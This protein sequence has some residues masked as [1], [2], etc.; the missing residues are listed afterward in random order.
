MTPLQTRLYD[1]EQRVAYTRSELVKQ[2]EGLSRDLAREAKRIAEPGYS[3]NSLG[4]CQQQAHNVDLLCA[5]LF[6]QRA[7]MG[8]LKALETAEA[9]K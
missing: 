9:A 2:T 1:A 8:I 4:I 7:A 5:M 3:P 6:E